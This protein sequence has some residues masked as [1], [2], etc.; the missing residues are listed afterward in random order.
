MIISSNDF[1]QAFTTGSH[2]SGYKLKS[3][4]L[5]MIVNAGD[6]PTYT[7]RI[8]S[9]SS[10]APGTSLGVLTH[11]AS[12]GNG[13]SVINEFKASGDGIDLQ[14]NTIYWIFSDTTAAVTT[15]IRILLTS[16]DDEDQSETTGWS[17]AN[18]CLYRSLSATTW[19]TQDP[20]SGVLEIHG[21]EK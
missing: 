20:G 21:T 4:K 19:I 13:N 16:S 14:P 7:V 5:A 10:G 18:T 2:A 17:I 11:P 8:S 1:A 9:D 6:K 12:L 3:L 15:N